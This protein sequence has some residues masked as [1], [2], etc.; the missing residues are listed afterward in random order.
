MLWRIFLHLRTAAVRTGF[1]V[2][3]R[4]PLRNRVLFATSHADTYPT[5]TVPGLMLAAV[6]ERFPSG[7]TTRA[8]EVDLDSGERVKTPLANLELIG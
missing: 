5:F 2:G 3:R 1:A 4:R 6:P 8:A 7:L